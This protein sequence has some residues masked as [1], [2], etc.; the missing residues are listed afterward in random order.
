MKEECFPHPGQPLLQGEISGTEREL[1]RLRGQCSSWL[2]ADRTERPIQGP[3]H[4]AQ[5][6]AQDESLLELPG[7]SGWEDAGCLNA[8]FRGQTRGEDWGWLCGD[9]LNGLE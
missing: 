1:Q 6:S 4:L 8:G 9:R 7:G 2:A 3:G 5:F